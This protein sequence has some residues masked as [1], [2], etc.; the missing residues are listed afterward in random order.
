MA[1][2][3]RGHHADVVISNTTFE[4]VI[5]KNLSRQQVLVEPGCT[6]NQLN[7]ILASDNVRVPLTFPTSPHTSFNPTTLTTTVDQA[8]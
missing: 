8:I 6:L 5:T 1:V 7:E 3:G 2:K 4:R